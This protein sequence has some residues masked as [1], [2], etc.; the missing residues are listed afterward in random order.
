MPMLVYNDQ[1]CENNKSKLD[2]NM[3]EKHIDDILNK[4][5]RESIL[6]FSKDYKNNL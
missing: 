3:L 5:T 1:D 4:E 2:L 6:D